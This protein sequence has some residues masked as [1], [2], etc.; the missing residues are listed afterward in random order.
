MLGRLYPKAYVD[1]IFHI[2][3]KK[4]HKDGIKNIVFDIDN[5]LVP[6]TEKKPTEK[7]IKLFSNLQKIGFKVCLLSNNKKERVE[8]FNEGLMLKAVYK[9]G[10]PSS[11]GINK[12]LSMLNANPNE[13]ALI[14]D[15]IFTDVWCGNR[16]GLYTILV[17][18]VSTSDEFT[19]RLKRGVEKIVLNLYLNKT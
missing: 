9:A 19:V 8:L 4:L 7:I 13:T 16:K 2:D 6:Y 15:Q 5:T 17:K 10:K 1:S 18:P 14:G 12:M 3:Y 11:K